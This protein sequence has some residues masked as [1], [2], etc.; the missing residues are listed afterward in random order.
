MVCGGMRGITPFSI[1]LAPSTRANL[2]AIQREWSARSG[3][4][5]TLAQVVDRLLESPAPRADLATEVADL[6]VD[7]RRAIGQISEKLAAR[8]PYRRAEWVFITQL[9][10]DDVDAGTSHHAIFDRLLW[11]AVYDALINVS[12]LL[13]DNSPVLRYV[14]AKAISGPAQR[15]DQLV[16][17]EVKRSLAAERS[18]FLAEAEAFRNPYVAR[19]LH[20][21]VRD[22]GVAIDDTGSV[23]DEQIERALFEV[24]ERLTKLA[25]RAVVDRGGGPILK[26][27]HMIPSVNFS[28]S[29]NFINIGAMVRDDGDLSCG[30]MIRGGQVGVQLSLVG[31]GRVHDLHVCLFGCGVD[32]IRIS[33]HFEVRGPFKDGEDITLTMEGGVSVR[34]GVSCAD[35]LSSGLA[36]LLSHGEWATQLAQLR[37]AYGR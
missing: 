30:V 22:A 6:L 32:K 25:V 13:A 3:E 9:I 4:K 26:S 2:E 34:M 15:G 1:R 33:R 37:D 16:G 24:K 21:A 35:E 10:L 18:A 17:R 11:G 23:S 20:V 19:A 27:P 7:P 28:Y 29:G 36:K 14:A 5:I 31:F 12:G 8:M